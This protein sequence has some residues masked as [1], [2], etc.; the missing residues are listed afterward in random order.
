MLLSKPGRN[1]PPAVFLDCV[2]AASPEPHNSLASPT[3]FCPLPTKLSS[4]IPKLLVSFFVCLLS[5][6]LGTVGLAPSISTQ[7]P[8][9]VEINLSQSRVGIQE[10]PFVPAAWTGLRGGRV[11]PSLCK[12][13][14][15]Y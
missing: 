7:V 10:E 3:Q 2:L 11:H 6:F 13:E 9:A 15:Q 8:R 14:L 12:W 4:E 5:Y 1:M